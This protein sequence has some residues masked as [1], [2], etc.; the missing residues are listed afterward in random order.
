MAKRKM[1][2]VYLP[3]GKWGRFYNKEIAIKVAKQNKG[4]VYARPSDNDTY[5]APTFKSGANK[6]YPKR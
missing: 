6:I 1:Y 2:G 4:S 5:D 3:N